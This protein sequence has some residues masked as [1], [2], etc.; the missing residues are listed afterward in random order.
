[1]RLQ[2]HTDL[3]RVNELPRDVAQNCGDAPVVTKRHNDGKL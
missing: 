1:M 3:G 2:G